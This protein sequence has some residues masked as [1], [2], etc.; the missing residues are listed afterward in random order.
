MKSTHPKAVRRRLLE[1]L[2]AAYSRNP[3]EMLEPADVLADGTVAREDLISNMYYLSDRGLVEMMPSYTPPMFAAVRITADG[4]DLVENEFEFN[5]RFPGEPGKL[6]ASAA[7]VPHLMEKLVEE[8]DFS[9]LDG[10]KRRCLLRDIQYL[11]D[12]LARPAERWRGE[13]VRTLM[14]WIDA[15]FKN[16]AKE[17]PSLPMLRLALKGKLEE[18]ADAAAESNPPIPFPKQP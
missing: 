10:E 18:P 9:E 14:R 4:I 15:Y 12:E 8:A 17:L 5:L 6:E 2:Y 13:V 11:R 1:L 16:P 7:N 3:L